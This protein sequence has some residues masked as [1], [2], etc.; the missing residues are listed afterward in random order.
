MFD[1][2]VQRLLPLDERFRQAEQYTLDLD[3][4]S[5]QRTEPP[6]RPDMMSGCPHHSIF[7]YGCRYCD[8]R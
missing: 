8:P 4:V 3:A 2:N 6:V 1:K 5:S 7:V